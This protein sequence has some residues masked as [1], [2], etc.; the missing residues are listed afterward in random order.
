[1]LSGTDFIEFFGKT[2]DGK[3][4]KALYRDPRY[5]LNDKVS[6]LTD[7]A[8]Y[9]LTVN[10]AGGNRR[11]E[12]TANNVAGNTLPAEPYFMHTL[13]TY[14]R[15]RSNGGYAV[16]VGTL[17]QP[18]L[19]YSSSYD[20]GEGFSSAEIAT[21]ASNTATLSNLWV[22]P[23]GPDP[24]FKIAVSGN[25]L[26]QRFIRTSING[27][28]VL[29][30]KV[31]YFNYGV[32]E[33]SF[34]LS[35]ITSNSATI[36]VTNVCNESPCPTNDKMVIHQYELTYPR[37]FHFGN[38]AT[39]FEF[40]L[41]ASAAGNYL[42]I[43]GFNYGTVAPVFY[44]LTNGRRYVANIATASRIRVVLEPSVTPRQLVL[45]GLQNTN[46]NLIST[47][48]ARNFID[49]TQPANQG[50]Y[51]IITNELLLNAANGANPVEEYR[52]Y[53]SSSAGGGYEGKTYFVDELTDQFGFGIKKHPVAIRNFLLFAR[54]KFAATP[55]H[56]FLIGKGVTYTSQR[57]NDAANATVQNKINIEKLNLVPTFGIPASDALL[58]ANPGSSI[59]Q[60]SIG[61]ISV[62]NAE[63]VAVY[64]KKI[65]EYETAQTALSSN[66]QD[67]EW[68]KNVVHING[69]SE[70]DLKPEID[71]HFE[72]YKD[73]IADTLFGAKVT[74]FAKTTSDAVE[75]ISSTT[76]PNLFKEGISLMTYFGHSS[77]TTLEFNLETPESYQNQGKYPL[78]IALG[79]SVGDF[80]TFSANRF[81][82]KGT[83][84][85]K[86]VLTPDKGT[87]GF[88]AS[89]NLGIVHYLDIW[90]TF[91]Y[92]AMARTHYGSPIGNII[93]DAAFSVFE[94]VGQGNAIAGQEDVYAR[95]N[96]EQMTLHGDPALKA[97]T[98][99]KP[100]YVVEESFVK[101]VPEFISVA[102]SSV[103][104]NSRFV[105]IGKAVNDSITIEVKRTYPNQTS[106]VVYTKKIPGIRY[107]D[108]LTFNL[109]IDPLRDKGTNKL[110]VTVDAENAVD[111]LFETNN[112][113]T[114][115][116]IVYE[117]EI[118]P[119]Y[120]YNF[121]IVNHQNIKLA[122]STANAFSPS[123]QFQME[124]DTTTL[125]N[126]TLKVTKTVTS[127]GGVLEFE[128]GLTFK[129][130]TVYYWRV[131]QVPTS[132]EYKWNMFSFV[133]LP[134]HEAGFN[135]S[136]VYQHMKSDLSRIS[137]D[138]TG[139]WRY[140]KKM[141]DVF[142]KHGVWAT[143]TG[144]E[145]DIVVNVNGESLI[146]NTCTTGIIVFNVFDPRS[147]KPWKNKIVNGEGLYGSRP[148]CA[149]NRISNFEYSI[150][151]T[152]GRRKAMDF[153]RMV[154]DDHYVVVRIQPR[155]QL[156]QNQY[157]DTW[158]TDENKYGTNNTLYHELIKNG[159][160]YI[161]SFYTPRALVAVYQNKRPDFEVR[162]VVS[163]GVYDLVTLQLE[164]ASDDTLGIVQS[165]LFG[166]AKA[167]KKFNWN[168]QST[169]SINSDY[170]KFE[171]IGVTKEGR[172][173]VLYKD[174]A[175]EEK[176]FD[177]SAINAK[178]YPFLQ[179]KLNTIDTVNYTPH[180]LKSW[181]LTYDPVP[182][183]A[184]APNIY[185]VIKD[186]LQAGEP[187]DLKVA[188]KNVSATAF[189]SIKVKLQIIDQNNVTHT[190]QNYK[191]K[192]LSSND[193]LTITQPIDSKQFKGIN[194]LFLEVNPDNDQLEQYHF[195][196]IAY[197]NFFVI[198]DTL[199]PLLDVTFDNVH[200]LNNDL[201]SPKPDI[202]IMLKDESQWTLLNDSSLVTVQ[203]RSY[204]NGSFR[205]YL[206]NTDTLKFTPA[207]STSN[208]TASINFRPHFM[209]DGT[210]E[211][212][213]SGKDKNNNKAGQLDY[214]VVFNVINKSMISNLLNYPNPFTTST[215]F[216]FTLTGS[217]VPQEFKI[218]I[219]TVTGKIVREISRQELGPIK[220]GRNITDFKWDG[221]DQYGQKLANGIYLY[222]VITSINGKTLEKFKSVGDNTD[223]YFNKG[224]GKM[225]LMR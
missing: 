167:W 63:E 78:F 163:R 136:H 115:D 92:K 72:K 140:Q 1:M 33:A 209:E 113:V 216:V 67:R 195:N 158:K 81:Q 138:S 48:Q 151:D 71:A 32:D 141:N 94:Y 5:H 202:L 156:S 101:V 13:G 61:R 93:K 108:S 45:V 160:S 194:A 60:M 215:A 170:Q 204:P 188:F 17:Q 50:N 98:H 100:D 124:M 87:I 114:K 51:L 159:V 179:I 112:T 66:R 126:S 80:F 97:N 142:I 110:T 88:V 211:M 199:N 161:D 62:I 213:V 116:F 122:A 207:Q 3:P 219:L 162:Q 27:D 54:H 168:G 84:P 201:V 206:P 70:P 111:E 19:I 99:A 36:Q 180:Q 64:L 2:N 75:Q 181:R 104:V 169:D 212:V 129:D 171:L 24:S 152:S 6:L 12:N 109:T 144:Q 197:R 82:E 44:D 214:R 77:A 184:L 57:T 149:E 191:Y 182:E 103:K 42:D 86:Y 174:L 37:Q 157:I 16:N 58:T 119:V 198:S 153:L 175:L 18:T 102:E 30:Q 28:E 56:V 218:Q 154:P 40:S 223:R 121:A 49:Y 120:P 190:L 83:I 107:S 53:R 148:T 176:E 96:V 139:T 165:P 76:L 46:I 147:F 68:M 217:E 22:Y 208:N 131:A 95:A 125:F 225:Y 34:P 9:F 38:V 164:C 35:K 55:Q 52:A 183:G 11:L 196:N 145:G 166:P 26:R 59:P 224:Y 123:R 132:G 210:Y 155:N 90:N 172:F 178:E 118:R 117:E 220:I 25:A 10:T 185:L 173:Q 200:I 39:F 106:E 43:T 130:S 41:P 205:T 79:C 89:T 186:T 193:T 69:I 65:K 4:D 135:Q 150:N 222:R 143:A 7:S 127:I 192:P 133:Y 134:N 91:V 14:F 8:T 74:T 177:I 21:N 128:P 189:D 137:L 47:L 15:N 29:R 23:S 146:R 105:N 221:T 203:V 31:D 85:E 73:I 20:I 187:I